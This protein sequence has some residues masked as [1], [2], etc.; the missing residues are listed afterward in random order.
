[1]GYKSQAYI[2]FFEYIA[3]LFF[4]LFIFFSL[5]NFLLSVDVA[6]P[7]LLVEE[8]SADKTSVESLY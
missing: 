5:A 1:M 4:F 8:I 6:F 3:Y 2:T 7:S